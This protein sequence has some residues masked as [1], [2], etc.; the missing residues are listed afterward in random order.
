M[1]KF[2]GKV[3]FA[4][5]EE[6]ELPVKDKNGVPT[7]IMKNHVF[8]KIQMMVLDK[9]LNFERPIVASTVDPVPTFVLPNAGDKFTTPEVRRY[10]VTLDGVPTVTF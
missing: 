5:R 1:L 8:I 6:R 4:T 10:E 2:S 7:S 3:I 9:D